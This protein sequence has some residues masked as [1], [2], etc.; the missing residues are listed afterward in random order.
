MTTIDDLAW[1]VTLAETGH[2]TRAA[3]QLN[4]SQ[5]TLSR[6]LARLERQVGAPLFDR[7]HK[8]LRLNES[9][10][11][12]LAHARRS[13]ME[14]DVAR[15]RIATLRD[16]DRGTVRLAFLHSVA[17]WLAPEVLRTFRAAAPD[18]TFELTQAAG[19]EI[20]DH[21][22]E[23]R[24]DVA[25]TAPRPDEEAITWSPLRREQLC[26]AVPGG[27]DLAGRDD[28]DLAD[29]TDEPF[30]MLREPI[31]LRRQTDDLCARAGITP[32]IA[33]ESTEIGTLEGLVA[34]GLGVAIVPAP[35]PHRAEPGVVYVPLTDAAA[36]RVIGLAWPRDRPRS[37]VVARFAAFVTA[38]TGSAEGSAEGSRAADPG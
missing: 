4:V 25:L 20:L 1:F 37:P 2:V 16:P 22:R 6:A 31:G 9:G 33:F 36:H 8:R 38:G 5:P 24:V 3:E 7:I 23:G 12:L 17:S 21:L 28:I 29:A 30:V 27:H 26:L 34:A 10:R 32:R 15:D 11:V 19:H 18:V 14:L 13:L 35:R